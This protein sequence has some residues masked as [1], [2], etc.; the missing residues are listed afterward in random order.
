MDQQKDDKNTELELLRDIFRSVGLKQR[1][2]AK[3]IEG[4]YL[5]DTFKMIKPEESLVQYGKTDLDIIRLNNRNNVILKSIGKL[6][7]QPVPVC[8]KITRSQGA[9]A[10]YYADPGGD[11]FEKGV[12]IPDF[13]AEDVYVG[14]Y[15][16][17]TS[18]LATCD[19]EIANFTVNGKQVSAESM[20]PGVIGENLEHS[21]QLHKDRLNI[22][23]KNAF[24]KGLKENI[25]FVYV[26]VTGD[27]EVMCE[28]TEMESAE[29]FSV[30]GLMIRN[31]IEPLSSLVV[32]NIARVN[33]LSMMIRNY[34]SDK[35]AARR[36]LAHQLDMDIIKNKMTSYEKL[37]WVTLEKVPLRDKNNQVYGMVATVSSLGI[38]EIVLNNLDEAIVF[39]DK[40]GLIKSI[41][42]KGEEIFNMTFDSIHRRNIE[43]VYQVTDLKRQPLDNMVKTIKTPMGSI[44]RDEDV[45]FINK[46]GREYILEETYC[47]FPHNDTEEL[48]SV[49]LI[50]TDV[51][52]NRK[53]MRQVTYQ[54]QHDVLTGLFNRLAFESK[55]DELIRSAKQEGT[56]HSFLFFDL[57]KFKPVNDEGGHLAGDMMLKQVSEIIKS[58]LRNSDYA[59]RLGGDEF[60]ALLP[61]CGLSDGMNVAE[62]IIRAIN[63]HVMDWEEKQ[64]KVGA[65]VGLV[66]FD[67]SVTEKMNL[68]S[69]ADKAA[70]KAKRLGGGRVITEQ[71]HANS[72]FVETGEV[73]DSAFL[74][75]L[76]EDDDYRIAIQKVVSIKNT[77]KIK[78][79]EVFIRAPEGEALGPDII[80]PILRRARKSVAIDRYMIRKIFGLMSA[81]KIE[82]RVGINLLQ[83][84]L[85]WEGIVP[86]L[87]ETGKAHPEVFARLFF[88]I[89]EQALINNFHKLN[90]IAQI[91]KPWGTNIIVDEISGNLHVIEYC[92]MLGVYGIKLEPILSKRVHTGK[93]AQ[94][95]LKYI[96]SAYS[97]LGIKVIIKHLE[98]THLLD[99]LKAYDIDYVQGFAIEKPHIIE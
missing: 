23:V 86:F 71:S 54:A 3:D 19:C 97:A 1:F 33:Q 5:F 2:Y 87:M 47:L 22:K 99:V 93:S 48:E 81:G 18:P 95:L 30:C 27:F 53:L 45:L 94:V 26:K 80:F 68:I 32:L 90:E 11:W 79:N 91:I 58:C 55:L 98:D 41:N 76:A 69:A 62:K 74:L 40:N 77:K 84:T 61:C 56:V 36:R 42:A 44:K 39:M 67:E 10:A 31:D 73:F 34:D 4:R 89:K 65:S 72:Q 85:R 78:Y 70:Y 96:T 7:S 59:A 12:P 14:V 50:L 75:Q 57:D 24:T 52:K 17:G 92:R 21:F 9:I 63:N 25:P 64:Y 88:E 49:I 60:G 46:A 13:L 66:L 15:V 16:S 29:V 51:T 28:I 20:N 37:K 35:E 43:A 83:E 38:L 82:G 6:T 8:M